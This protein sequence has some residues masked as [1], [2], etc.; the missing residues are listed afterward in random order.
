MS[1]WDQP[2]NTS[3]PF[4]AYTSTTGTAP[5]EYAG[6]WLRFVAIIIDGI[7]MNIANWVL[8]A[9]FAPDLM[10]MATMSEA[11]MDEAAQM[12][13]LAEMMGSLQL[14]VALSFLVGIAY[15]AGMHSSAK[16][17]TLGKMAVGIKVTD[18]DGNRISLGKAI[19][20]QFAQ[21]LSGLTLG[22]GY[23]MAGFTQ[24]KQALHD[25]ICNTL[26]VKAQR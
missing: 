1:N 6:F 8:M 21:I 15:F 17:A 12:A 25:I 14:Y 26:V 13:M 9:I 19:G 16:Q 5:T 20:R 23:I 4:D 11:N 7:I 2:Q 22:I 10:K 3:A 24:K 18:L